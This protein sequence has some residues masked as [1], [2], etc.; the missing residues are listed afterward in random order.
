[1]QFYNLKTRNVVDIPEGS[2]RR[3]K[4]KRVSDS[5]LKE[6]P[7]SMNSPFVVLCSVPRSSYNSTPLSLDDPIFRFFEPV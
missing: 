5:D 7:E 6:T 4:P 3:R 2:L 1:M